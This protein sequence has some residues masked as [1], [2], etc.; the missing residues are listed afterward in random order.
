MTL[1]HDSELRDF[2]NSIEERGLSR[3]D[4]E[5]EEGPIKGP[6]A[7]ADVGPLTGTVTVRFKPTG[8][9]RQY[10]TRHDSSWPHLFH[11]DL[12]RGAFH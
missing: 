8:A 9:S 5:L 12:S 6:P 2:W 1:I 3:T 4:F 11:M 10:A 7:E